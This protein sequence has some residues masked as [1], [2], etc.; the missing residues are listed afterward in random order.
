ME[1]S[2]IVA[3]GKRKRK[4]AD[5]SNTRKKQSSTVPEF[6][7]YPLD[8]PLSLLDAKNVFEGINLAA[9]LNPL[10][11][12]SYQAIRTTVSKLLAREITLIDVAAVKAI[13]QDMLVIKWV[14][15]LYRNDGSTI[16][17]KT[18]AGLADS[19]QTLEPVLTIAFSD[20]AMFKKSMS[21]GA[22][23]K[24]NKLAVERRSMDFYTRLMSFWQKAKLLE[25]DIELFL[26][27]AKS[28]ALPCNPYIQT[29]LINEPSACIS[30]LN[31]HDPSKNVSS[32]DIPTAADIVSS[33]KYTP[34]YRDQIGSTHHHVTAIRE[35]KYGK[36]P[37]A[38]EQS[39]TWQSIQSFTKIYHCYEHQTEALHAIQ[40]GHSVI[41]SASTSSGKSLVYQLAILYELERIPHSRSIL[42]F[43]T[44]AL[45][46]DQKRSLNNLICQLPHLT[47]S[48]CDTFDGD[49]STNSNI[50]KNLRN[51]LS[52]ALT[53]PDMLHAAILPH[54][55]LWHSFLMNLRFV[56]IDEMHYYTGKL[57]VHFALVMRRLLRICRFYGNN[58]VQFIGCSATIGNPFELMKT[59]V[60]VEDVIAVTNDTSGMGA[61]HQIIWNP[62]YRFI[63]FPSLGRLSVLDET[64]QVFAFCILKQVK[65]ICFTKTRN[66]CE[67][68]FRE[69][70]AVIQK[71]N[72]ELSKK[73][74]SYRGGYNSSDRR[75]IESQLFCGELLGIVST[76]ALELG[77]DIGVLDV[78]IHCGFPFSFA[79]YHQQLGRAGRRGKH[80]LSILI[81]ED[82]NSGDQCM[83]KNPSYLFETT[84]FENVIVDISNQELLEPHLQ[85]ASAEIPFNPMQDAA[86]FVS[87]NEDATLEDTINRLE[88]VIESIEPE[89]VAFTLYP[90]AVFLHMGNVYLIVDVNINQ[91]LAR[92]KRAFPC[93]EYITK[94]KSLTRIDPVST[95]GSKSVQTQLKKIPLSTVLAIQ[96]KNH[97]IEFSIHAATHIL[98][99]ILPLYT[100][101]NTDSMHSIAHECKSPNVKQSRSPRIILYDSSGQMGLVERMIRFMPYLILKAAHS[102]SKCE[103]LDGCESCVWSTSCRYGNQAIDKHGALKILNDLAGVDT[104]PLAL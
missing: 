18:A 70:V 93:I 51:T 97:D 95:R 17:L 66:L 43:P 15:S 49:T 46:Q 82:T 76:N 26:N 81:A 87:P 53:N 25:T 45:A 104:D 50:R 72:P 90:D 4:T 42:I 100:S 30:T 38:I 37:K 88:T 96:Q 1:R 102:L 69:T 83:V 86:L 34:F 74:A 39:K 9:A 16:E 24:M 6:A 3:A 79:S 10:C 59:L 21:K 80:S 5:T 11:E 63:D 55:A 23:A 71:T 12:C 84:S 67:L 62:P 22:S 99:S 92:A 77:I 33:I 54:H 60:G 28:T 89:K 78:V 65:T 75:R 29:S 31:V 56:V 41:L 73:I 44:K 94:C 19:I 27:Q 14:Q 13:A 64:A 57:G 103:C 40:D 68:V 8:L 98:K 35:A 47:H 7:L 101:T 91:K 85:C 20:T 52:I 2:A 48:V 61:R 32:S 36:L 58:H